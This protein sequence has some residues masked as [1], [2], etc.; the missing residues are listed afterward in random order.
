M[1]R[2]LLSIPGRQIRT[3]LETEHD[4]P[5]AGTQ[6]AHALPERRQRVGEVAKDEMAE[7]RIM[8]VVGQ[9]KRTVE[10]AEEE[11]WS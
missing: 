3:R 9:G 8:T 6:D 5:A 7:H 2:E 1:S 11:G 10:I 4:Q